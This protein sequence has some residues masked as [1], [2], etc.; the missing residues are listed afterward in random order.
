MVAILSTD[1]DDEW[2]GP[3]IEYPYKERMTSAWKQL[4][5]A[6][7]QNITRTYATKYNLFA[8][9]DGPFEWKLTKLVTRWMRV[10]IEIDG[11]IQ[12]RL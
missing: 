7:L 11:A 3:V 9:Q 6:D 12:T 2:D 5:L 10:H 4:S 8:T 1:I